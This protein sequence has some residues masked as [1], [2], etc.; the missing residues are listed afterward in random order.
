MGLS[1]WSLMDDLGFVATAEVMSAMM[2][3]FEEMRKRVSPKASP[4]P[5]YHP[6]TQTKI[7]PTEI[8]PT[9]LFFW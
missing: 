2:V 9:V 3:A 7:V 8:V 5:W 1:S 6:A 4:T